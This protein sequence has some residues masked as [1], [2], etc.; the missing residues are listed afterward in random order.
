VLL[1]TQGSSEGLDIPRMKLLSCVAMCVGLEVV[2]HRGVVSSGKTSW[3]E[4][5]RLV[6]IGS[7]GSGYSVD[8]V[9]PSQMHLCLDSGAA[10]RDL[11]YSVDRVVPS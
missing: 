2:Y 1:S 3:V 8:R 9:V 10:A 11:G 4:S 7:I 6:L 5:G